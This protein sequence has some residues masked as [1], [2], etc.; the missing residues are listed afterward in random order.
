[1]PVASGLPA[2]SVGGPARARRLDAVLS[3]EQR[4]RAWTRGA[5][6]EGAHGQKGRTGRRGARAE[7]RTGR[8]GARAE[9]A[10]GQK[11]R[12]GRRGARAEGAHGQKRIYFGAKGHMERAK[13]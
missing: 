5:R 9:G 4:I 11:G 7:G 1:V 6:A 3:A 13:I 2:S 10:H 8:R 12:T